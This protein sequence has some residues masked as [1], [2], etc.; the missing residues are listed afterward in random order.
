M[1]ANIPVFRLINPTL[2]VDGNDDISPERRV[3]KSQS[4]LRFVRKK[5][6]PE[7]RKK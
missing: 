5:K 2:N 7:N 1:L 6:K 3:T 4:F